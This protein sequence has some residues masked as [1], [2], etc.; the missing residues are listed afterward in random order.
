MVFEN[1]PPT[2]LRVGVR[3]DGDERFVSLQGEMDFTAAG[4]LHDA[5]DVAMRGH[6]S[7][8]VVDL[9]RLT[10]MDSTGIHWLLAA[11]QQCNEEACRLVLVGGAP[12]IQRVLEISGVLGSFEIVADPRDAPSPRSS[13]DAASS[14]RARGARHE[15]DSEAR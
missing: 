15:G 13:Q 8:L 7:V 12:H 14:R 2:T 6:P 5:L 10:F 11:R 1:R 9:T 3:G 4:E